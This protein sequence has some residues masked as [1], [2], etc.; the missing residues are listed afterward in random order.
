VSGAIH[1]ELYERIGAGYRRFRRAAPRIAELI[2]V[3]AP[4]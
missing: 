1:G 2:P 4:R 3:V